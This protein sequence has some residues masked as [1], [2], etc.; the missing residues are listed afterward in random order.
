M[1][2][3]QLEN[4]IPRPGIVGDCDKHM[5]SKS[6]LQTFI[7]LL[8]EGFDP[9]VQFLFA[10]KWVSKC[11]RE[12][13]KVRLAPKLKRLH[14]Q[15]SKKKFKLPERME[16]NETAPTFLESGMVRSLRV[17]IWQYL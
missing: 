9:E 5:E 8:V 16:K 10:M 14:Q 3:S 13:V 6:I 4:P 2:P 15:T 7:L 12:V 17:T 1:F 11:E